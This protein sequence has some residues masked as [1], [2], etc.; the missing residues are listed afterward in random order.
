MSV[1]QIRKLQ[2]GWAKLNP[3]SRIPNET[4]SRTD[5]SRTSQSSKTTPYSEFVI[6]T[7]TSNPWTSEVVITTT[8]PD[9]T[10]LWLKTHSPGIIPSIDTNPSWVKTGTFLT[11]GQEE[12]KIIIQNLTENG[13]STISAPTS[14]VVRDR[15][16]ATTRYLWIVPTTVRFDASDNKEFC[17]LTT[18]ICSSRST[19]LLSTPFK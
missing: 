2:S 7:I 16:D 1:T 6:S 15:T 13:R 5:T 17:K 3:D 14:I 18:V 11:S 12:L 8:E 10:T 19:L 4:R 9:N